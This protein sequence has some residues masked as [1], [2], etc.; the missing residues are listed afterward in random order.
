MLE[1]VAHELT[2]TL[3]QSSI[4]LENCSFI[5]DFFQ[6]QCSMAMSHYIMFHGYVILNYQI[7]LCKFK[8]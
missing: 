8:Y 6:V 5:D 1:E 3:Q 7:V 4:G 2:M